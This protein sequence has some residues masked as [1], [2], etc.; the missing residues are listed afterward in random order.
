[1]PNPFK[2]GEYSI[3]KDW[4]AHG[5]TDMRE[6]IAVSSDVYFYQVGGGFLNQQKGLGITNIEKYA[7]LFGLGEPIT[8]GF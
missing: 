8:Q 4:K 7:R 3:F 6:A 5:F 2:P 1:L